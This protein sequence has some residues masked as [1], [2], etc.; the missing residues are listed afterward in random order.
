[1]DYRW[2]SVMHTHTQAGWHCRYILQFT[3]QLGCRCLIC[4]EQKSVKF[5]SCLSICLIGPK[6]MLFKQIQNIVLNF[7]LTN[8]KRSRVS[9]KYQRNRAI[10]MVSD[11]ITCSYY[12]SDN[13]LVLCQFYSFSDVVES[14][15]PGFNSPDLHFWKSPWIICPECSAFLKCE[16]LDS[17]IIPGWSHMWGFKCKDGN[18]NA[19]LEPGSATEELLKGFLGTWVRVSVSVIPSRYFSAKILEEKS[20]WSTL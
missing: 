10:Q 11:I 4:V 3:T 15:S 1:M 7:C 20:F 5:F 14:Q 13:Y 19:G 18:N 2:A 8:T 17:Q 16:P 12:I 9:N 6:S